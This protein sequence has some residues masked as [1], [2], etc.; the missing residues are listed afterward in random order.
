MA[1][2]DPIG[3]KDAVPGLT[4]LLDHGVSSIRSD[5][6]WTLG[7]IAIL[8]SAAV[9]GAVPKLVSLLMTRTQMSVTELFQ[10]WLMLA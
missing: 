4:R 2:F 10:L 1:P 6:A 8:D 3:A 5:A 9:D 7:Q